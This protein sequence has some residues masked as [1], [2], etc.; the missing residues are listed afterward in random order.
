MCSIGNNCICTYGLSVTH[1][2]E[3]HHLSYL[4]MVPLEE[5]PPAMAEVHGGLRLAPSK[6]ENA[7]WDLCYKRDFEYQTGFRPR[8]LNWNEKQLTTLHFLGGGM[9]ARGKCRRQP[10]LLSA[11]LLVV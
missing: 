4:S 7:M 9:Q 1:N 6:S 5:V 8:R 2:P 11:L 10:W 3:P